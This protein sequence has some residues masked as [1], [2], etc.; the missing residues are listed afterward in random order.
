[1]IYLLISEPSLLLKSTI[2]QIVDKSISFKDEFNYVSFDFETNSLETIIDSLQTPAFGSERKVVIA[3]NPF[4]L[5]EEKKKSPLA[6]DIKLLEEYLYQPNETTD[7]IIVCP[8]KYYKPKHKIITII[9]SIGEIQNLLIESYEDLQNYA[10]TLSK[11]LKIEFEPSAFMLFLSRCKDVTT[12]EK[13]ISKLSLYDSYLDYESVDALVPR[14]LEENVFD[15]SNAILKRQTQKVMQ[16][17]ADLKKLKTEPIM[18]I[19]LLANQFRFM[20]Q[21]G[22][23][24]KERYS[25]EQIINE[26]KVHPYRVKLAKENLNLHS[27]EEIKDYLVKLA[28]LD[29]SIKKGVKDRFIDLEIFLSTGR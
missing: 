6:N 16:I 3:K 10:Q 22:I 29:I 26:L 23:L 20:L 7:F 4:F 12:L 15:L 9:Q 18:L 14:P 2:N 25:D 1:M 21:V 24:Q 13:E 28:N 5:E 17:Y 8:K 19:G 27:I 11:K